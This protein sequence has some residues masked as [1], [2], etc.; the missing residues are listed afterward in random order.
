MG[1]PVNYRLMLPLLSLPTWVKLQNALAPAEFWS[2]R[3]EKVKK[4][5]P[6]Y[7]G[8]L[9]SIACWQI[10]YRTIIEVHQVS[11]QEMPM[12][13]FGNS[14]ALVNYANMSYFTQNWFKF[15]RLV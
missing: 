10:N 4:K 11:S 12:I 6:N 13:P 9:I 2:S 7:K 14:E 8:K 1:A 3:V 15:R 5:G